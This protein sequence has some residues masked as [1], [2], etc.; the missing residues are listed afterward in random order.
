MANEG[1]FQP[2]YPAL[3]YKYGYEVYPYFKYDKKLEKE[4]RALSDKPVPTLKRCSLMSTIY[5]SKILKY[6]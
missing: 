1:K 2:L 6:T 5:G 3:R 4:V